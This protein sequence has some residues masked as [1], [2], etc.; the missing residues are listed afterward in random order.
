M[1][2][3]KNDYLLLIGEE[4]KRLYVLIKVVSLLIPT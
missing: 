1:H 3:K 4:G 2:Q